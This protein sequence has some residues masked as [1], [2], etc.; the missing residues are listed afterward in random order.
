MANMGWDRGAHQGGR[1]IES[2]LKVIV[3]HVHAVAV[4]CSHVVNQTKI[5][6]ALWELI[7]DVDYNIGFPPAAWA[8]HS[9]CV[10][11]RTLLRREIFVSGIPTM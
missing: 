6:N 9:M 8:D 5:Q 10:L 4:T 3:G 2:K 1:V 7:E 11:R